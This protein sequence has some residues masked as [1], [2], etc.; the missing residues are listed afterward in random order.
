MTSKKVFYTTI[1]LSACI[2]AVIVSF[3]VY[4][5]EY[6][7]FG[8]AKGKSIK[9]WNNERTSKYLLSYNYIPANFEGILIGPSVS[10]NI[11]T[12]KI[13]GFKIYNTSINGGNISELKYI[14]ENVIH[15]GNLK[16]IIVCLYPYLTKNH[17]RKT[18]S[19][20]P[21]EYWG[22]LGSWETVKLY[23]EKILTKLNLK[24][25]L[26]NDYG[27][28]NFLIEAEEPIIPRQI[29]TNIITKENLNENMITNNNRNFQTEHIDE[30][31]YNELAYVLKLARDRK[32]QIFAFYYPYYINNFDIVKF[33]SYKDR[34]DKLFMRHDV[35]WDFN[36]DEHLKF[37][38]DSNNYSDKKHLSWTGTNYL[39]CEINNKL[40]LFYRRNFNEAHQQE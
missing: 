19:I 18:S 34:I 38:N 12:K 28:N 2:I 13:S 36:N 40:N 39:I 30:V 10:D 29:G 17:G 26:N 5:N 23:K 33:N 4:M 20:D 3:N 1:L 32:T 37:R 35:V 25:N 15:N 21:R 6:G 11:E 7:L 8:N 22:T 31:A 24:Q 14:A 27:C 9:V 16:F